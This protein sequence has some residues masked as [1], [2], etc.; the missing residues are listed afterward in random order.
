MV[1]R[2]EA[3]PGR[4]FADVVSAKCGACVFVMDQCHKF[5]LQRGLVGLP[6]GNCCH[7]SNRQVRGVVLKN[8][9]L[10]R[11]AGSALMC[12]TPVVL[13]AQAVPAP[14]NVRVD[15]R[16]VIPPSLIGSWKLSLAE[17]K[18]A[19]PSKAP[20]MQYRTFDY[21]ADGMLLCDYITAAAD[22]KQSSGNWTS[23]FDGVFRA[24][25]TRAYGSTPFAMVTLV[26]K[27]PLTLSLKAAKHGVVFEW[28]DFTLSADGNT[29]TFVYYTHG[30][31][32]D[33]KNT[34]VYHR[35]NLIN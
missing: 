34:A 31:T 33:L 8:A 6:W 32:G 5:V 9:R 4:C 16:E 12:A 30:T 26:A 35:W 14:A 2:D 18:Y 1:V 10:L 27:D 25:Y 19:D 17:S 11:L 28:G 29:M 13:L 22:G 21:T 24:E 23:S 7:N 15:A 20:K 3:R